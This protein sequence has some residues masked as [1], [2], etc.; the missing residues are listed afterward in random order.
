MRTLGLLSLSSSFYTMP[1]SLVLL[2]FLLCSHG[3]IRRIHQSF[4]VVNRGGRHTPHT[5]I[6]HPMPH[7]PHPKTPHTK[8]RYRINYGYMYEYS[9]TCFSYERQQVCISLLR[10]FSY[11]VPPSP[12]CTTTCRAAESGTQQVV[13]GSIVR[14]SERNQLLR[15]LWH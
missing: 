3:S 5:N 11:C 7:N 9:G 12:L 8:P 13:V 4:E 15:T 2:L 6:P 14:T 10:Y 1:R